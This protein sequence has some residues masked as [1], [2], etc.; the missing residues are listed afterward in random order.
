M[1]KDCSILILRCLWVLV[2]FCT[3]SSAQL[4]TAESYRGGSEESTKATAKSCTLSVDA[5]FVFLQ[6][7]PPPP[8]PAT[9]HVKGHCIRTSAGN[10]LGELGMGG[11]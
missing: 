4:R 2:V 11:R 8:P 7:V 10:G 5:S 3:P 9:S 6:F 1:V